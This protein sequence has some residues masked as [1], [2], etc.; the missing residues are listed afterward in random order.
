MKKDGYDYFLFLATFLLVTIVSIAGFFVI[1]VL[2]RL[3]VLIIFVVLVFIV[4]APAVTISV[5]AMIVLVVLVGVVSILFEAFLCGW[6]HRL[7]V[8][9]HK[10]CTFFAQVEGFACFVIGTDEPESAIARVEHL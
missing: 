9:L 4:V 3:V 2:V 8:L 1:V 5:A 6:F 7:V 10:H